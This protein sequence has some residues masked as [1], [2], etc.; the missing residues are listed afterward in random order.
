MASLIV[1]DEKRVSSSKLKLQPDSRNTRSPRVRPSSLKHKARFPTETVKQSEES[2]RHLL[3]DFEHGR[4]SAF[5]EL[6]QLL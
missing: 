3:D 1:E 6:L 4:L 2:L 5:G